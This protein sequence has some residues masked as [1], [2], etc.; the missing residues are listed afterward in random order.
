MSRGGSITVT[1]QK[2]TWD[3]NSFIELDELVK[4]PKDLRIAGR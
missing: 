2:K 3:R 4:G 1:A